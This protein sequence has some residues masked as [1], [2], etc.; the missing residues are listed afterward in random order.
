MSV[1]FEIP[2]NSMLRDLD[3]TLSE[4]VK[5][6][7]DEPARY[8]FG[9]GK[10]EGVLL[11]RA[12]LAFIKL[13]SRNSSNGFFEDERAVPVHP[14]FERIKIHIS[15]IIRVYVNSES[16]L[17]QK[18][19]NKLI[20]T[21]PNPLRFIVLSSM[22]LFTARVYLQPK[23]MQPDPIQAYVDGYFNLVIDLTD[24][25][26]RVP[27]IPKK[28]QEGQSLTSATL[29]PS[30]RFKGLNESDEQLIREFIFDEAPKNGRKMQFHA[31][32]S[33]INAA[34][35]VMDYV[36]LLRAAL[37]SIDL[38]FSIAICVLCNNPDDFGIIPS[39]LNVFMC[40]KKI[41]F[42][43]RAL[44]V[45]AL[46][47]AQSSSVTDCMELVALSNIFVATSFQFTQKIKPHGGIAAVIASVCDG[48]NKREFSDITIYILKIALVVAAYSDKTGSD[49]IAL[50]LEITV[51]PFASIFSLTE[52]FD[53]LKRSIMQKEEA[54][55]NVRGLI[56]KSIVQFLTDDVTVGLKPADISLG[57]QDIHDFIFSHIDDFINLVIFLND[58][59]KSLHP[60]VQMIRFAY[61]MCVKHAIV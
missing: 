31:F 29:P 23:S 46:R 40:D 26:V 32:L 56:E 55:T 7:N 27:L 8:Y 3:R 41:D 57:I 22:S 43:I 14:L 44:S 50:L 61:E 1:E 24:N 33:V 18:F 4:V 16:M 17:I 10:K 28:F 36:N 20:P 15:Q 6:H 45:A 35:P 60:T 19:I 11:S 52:Q 21:N 12:V 30:L 54:S 42:F 34:R 9:E 13:L 49:V 38:S 5:L 47:F 25:V 2:K 48:M 53:E 58:R 51:R 37:T 39:L 59:K